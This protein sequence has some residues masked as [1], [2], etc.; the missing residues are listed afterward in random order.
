MVS[1]IV[2][3]NQ[4]EDAHQT[5]LFTWAA[6]NEKNY[7]DLRKLYAVPNGGHRNKAVAGKL[8]AQGVRAGVLDIGLDVARHGY[9]GL[10]I[11]MKRPKTPTQ[12]AGVLSDAQEKRIDDL[13]ADGYFVIVC[14]TW[15]EASATLVDYLT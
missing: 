8:K 15:E 5:A 6:L 11:E 13:R 14:Y 2:L 7:P 10:R 1:R 9:H 12:T 3:S 4:S